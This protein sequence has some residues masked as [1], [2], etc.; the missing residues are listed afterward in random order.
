MTHSKI[1][2]FWAA[3]LPLA[4]GACAITPP[5]AQVPAPPPATWQAPLPH[6]GSLGDLVGYRLVFQSGLALG[7]IGF[8]ACAFAQSFAML[9]AGRALQGLSIALVLSCAPA[10]ATSNFGSN[11]GSSSSSGRS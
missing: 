1:R 9:L 10:L 8:A 5:P 7:T 11:L 2:R 4:L 3:C 6:Q